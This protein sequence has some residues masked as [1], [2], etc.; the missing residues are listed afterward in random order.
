MNVSAGMPAPSRKQNGKFKHLFLL[1][2]CL[3][4][5]RL[6]VSQCRAAV[7]LAPPLYR[8]QLP[9]L[10]PQTR[11]PGA[12]RSVRMYVVCVYFSLWVFLDNIHY[13]ST[14][15][16][17]NIFIVICHAYKNH[18]TV[19]GINRHKVKQTESTQP[20]HQVVFLSPIW[21]FHSW[22]QFMVAVEAVCVW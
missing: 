10:Q 4:L 9:D 20:I 19:D 5:G 6:S 14:R 1:T 7:C 2:W 3:C 15:I 8:Q 22:C 11:F 13:N 18:W 21:Y 17:S 12:L 16:S